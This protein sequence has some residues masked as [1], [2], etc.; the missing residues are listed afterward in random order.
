MLI[1]GTKLECKLLMCKCKILTE[2]RKLKYRCWTVIACRADLVF[3]MAGNTNRWNSHTTILYLV[4]EVVPIFLREFDYDTDLIFKFLIWELIKFQ[5][6]S[7]SHYVISRCLYL[8]VIE[9]GVFQFGILCLLVTVFEQ[10]NSCR[11]PLKSFSTCTL[12]IHRNI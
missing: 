7:T 2:K 11:L 6:F 3:W 4:I 12:K 8:F 5:S 9:T 10:Y 1:L